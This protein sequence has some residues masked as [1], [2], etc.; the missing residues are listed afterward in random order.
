V[1]QSFWSSKPHIYPVHGFEVPDK[2]SSVS[3]LEA[4][5]PRRYIRV[6][7]EEDRTFLTADVRLLGVYLVFSAR[8]AV[9][10]DDDELRSLLGALASE[11]EAGADPLWRKW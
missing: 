6:V 3:E 2:K 11:L 10:A 9:L 4:R 8:F 1:L 5:V 7:H